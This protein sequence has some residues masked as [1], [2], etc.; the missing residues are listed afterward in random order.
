MLDT[1]SIGRR[2]VKEDKDDAIE[3]DNEKMMVVV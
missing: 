3:R 2:D 1:Q